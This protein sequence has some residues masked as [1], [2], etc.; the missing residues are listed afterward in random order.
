M[1]INVGPFRQVIA[2]NA[3]GAGY[4][5]LGV[6]VITEKENA[7]P[8]PPE[9]VI[10]LDDDQEIIDQTNETSTIITHI[11]PTTLT[12]NIVWTEAMPLPTEE[13]FF[14]PF[15]YAGFPGIY[16]IYG[17]QFGVYVGVTGHSVNYWGTP[18]VTGGIFDSQEDAEARAAT[19]NSFY[20]GT[21]T[22]GAYRSDGVFQIVASSW[23][24]MFAT[25]FVRN[26]PAVDM[27]KT[28][29]IA[30]YLIKTPKRKRTFEVDVNDSSSI[31]ARIFSGQ[32]PKKIE[33]LEYPEDD[34]ALSGTTDEGTY[35]VETEVPSVK[36]GTVKITVGGD[37]GGPSG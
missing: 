27:Y 1:A 18:G 21:G 20:E 19:Y 11:P 12:Y 15:E 32:K 14:S 2:Y 8:P 6:S 29:R 17:G 10:H 5:L 35:E 34:E 24:G 31:G 7:P 23:P 30:E 33:D 25:Q 28:T 26:I 36:H 13:T 37:G 3:P 4:V 22:F 9:I 16:G